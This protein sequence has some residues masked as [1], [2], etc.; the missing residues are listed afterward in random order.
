MVCW[1]EARHATVHMGLQRNRWLSHWTEVTDWGLPWGPLSPTWVLSEST[2]MCPP[3]AIPWATEE[4]APHAWGP[5]L[6]GPHLSWGVQRLKWPFWLML[7]WRQRLALP[8]SSS[9]HRISPW[10]F[11]FL[12]FIYVFIWAALVLAV[13]RNLIASCGLFVV[14][15]GLQSRWLSGCSTGWYPTEYAGSSSWPGSTCIP[16]N[17]KADTTTGPPGSPVCLGLWMRPSPS[18]FTL[19]LAR[20]GS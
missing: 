2:L 9:S 1:A 6:L 18:D 11:I 17:C 20:L 16:L 10:S 15:H 12:T 7:S 8:A 3:Q 4:Q 14:A 19:Q 5:N 13:C